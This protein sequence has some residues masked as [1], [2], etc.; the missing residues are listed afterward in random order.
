MFLLMWQCNV[1]V[2]KS[3]PSCLLKQKYSQLNGNHN[4]LIKGIYR[5]AAE[6]KKEAL[7]FGN[8]RVVFLYGINKITQEGRTKMQVR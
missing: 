1:Q 4:L 2:V 8:G 7:T 6:V 3:C 5:F